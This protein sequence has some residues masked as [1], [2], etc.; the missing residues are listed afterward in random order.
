MHSIKVSEICTYFSILL[1][2]NGEKKIKSSNKFIIFSVRLKKYAILDIK[3][4][5][6]NIHLINLI[7]KQLF[8]YFFFQ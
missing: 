8:L 3:F 4:I 1:T 2:K 6:T 7:N 5:K